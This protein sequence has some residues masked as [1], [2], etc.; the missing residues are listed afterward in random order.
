MTH[1]KSETIRALKACTALQLIFAGAFCLSVSTMLSH[2][3][4]IPKNQDTHNTEDQETDL[5]PVIVTATGKPVGYQGA[6]EWVYSA[7]YA[8]SVIGRD[9]IKNASVRSAADLFKQT[10]GVTIANNPQDSGMSVNVRGLQDMNRINVTVDG[11]RQ[12]FQKS[13]HYETGRFYIDPA[14]IRQIEIEKSAT[15]GAGGAGALGGVVEFETIN[16][17]DLLKDG[18]NY[19]VEG[20]LST[21][22]NA[23]NFDGNV[24]AAARLGNGIEF[25]AGVSHKNLGTY[26][27]G[28]NGTLERFDEAPVFTGS[29]AWSGLAKVRFDLNENHDLTLSSIVF[30]DVMT[31]STPDGRLRNYSDVLNLTGAVNYTYT[32]DNDLMDLEL[33]LTASTTQIDEFREPRKDYGAIS[34]NYSIQTYGFDLQNTSYFDFNGNELAWNYGVEGF[35]DI[36]MTKSE[37]A[38][39]IDD[40]AKMWFGTDPSGKRD[41]LSGFT[42]L[43]YNHNDFLEING[44]VRYDYFNVEGDSLHY[45]LDSFTYLDEKISNSGGR[46][47]PTFSAAITPLEGVQLFG[48]YS[49]GYRIPTIMETA[50][51]GDHIGQHGPWLNFKPN[52]YLE[53]EIAY[54]WEGGANLRFS[55]L[56][57]ADDNLRMKLSYFHREIDNYTVLGSQSLLYDIPAVSYVNLIDP[58]KM[59]GIE[60]E[61]NYDAGHAYAGLGFSRTF[62]DL[63]ENPKFTNQSIESDTYNELVYYTAIPPE[64]KIALDAG[65]RL[66]DQKLT[67]GGRVTHVMPNKLAGSFG[68]EGF[69]NKDYTLFD[70]YGAYAFNEMTKLQVNVDNITDVAYVDALTSVGYPAAGRTITAAINFKF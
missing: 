43:T 16:A 68:L 14:F 57:Q 66:F 9:T 41:V 8:V 18:Q 47:S 56:L 17:S 53:G 39:D 1:E 58:V 22:N 59:Q 13:G 54:T 2:A 44:G 10:P 25:V 38:G 35:R 67:V 29:D 27:I 36:G 69:S 55:D 65:V 26:D 23:Y 11:A 63:P 6:P 64:M 45:S 30:N 46:L 7:P 61:V 34:N 5:A 31:T 40:S 51:G 19:G 20:K 48:K 62:T 70:L 4:P 60:F 42:S 37:N 3:K 28:Q 12:N 33:N 15:S 52:P 50:L 24:A 49:E 32:P 21:G